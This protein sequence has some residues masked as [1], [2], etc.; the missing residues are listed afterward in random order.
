[1][2]MR[3]DYN[4]TRY[5]VQ[6]SLLFLKTVFQDQENPSSELKQHLVSAFMKALIP[7]LEPLPIELI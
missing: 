2:K 6:V 4:R 5:L 3:I 7:F 1:M